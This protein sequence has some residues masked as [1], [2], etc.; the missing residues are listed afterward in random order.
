MTGLPL[1][2]GPNGVGIFSPFTWGWKQIQFPK[3]R[4]YAPKNT[5]RLKK[6]KNRVILWSWMLFKGNLIYYIVYLRYYMSGNTSIYT[7]NI[8]SKSVLLI[9]I[10]NVNIMLR[11]GRPRGWSSS[12][13]REKN[14][15][16]SKSSRPALRSTQTPIQWVPGALS[17]G[18]KRQG[19]EV[20][21]SPPTSAEVKKMW[22]YTSTPHTPSWRSA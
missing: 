6:S 2:K 10:C 3:R 21:H 22:I 19:R 16:F 4:V 17:P 5:G 18:V 20:D 12:P 7:F 1:S 13:G 15:L 14:I 8:I 11:A 9:L